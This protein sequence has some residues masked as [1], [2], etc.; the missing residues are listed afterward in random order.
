MREAGSGTRGPLDSESARLRELGELLRRTREAR[1][2]TI[3][4]AVEATK[5][6]GRYL[7]AIEQGNLLVLPG[8]VYARGFVRSYAEYLG[9]DGMEVTNLYLGRGDNSAADRPDPSSRMSASKS[10]ATPP[11]ARRRRVR[12]RGYEMRRRPGTVRVI[13][14]I[15]A[16]VVIFTVL[17]VVYETQVGSQAQGIPV[18]KPPTGGTL[19]GSG[20]TSGYAAGAPAGSAQAG[21][22]GAVQSA[23]AAKSGSAVTL[24]RIA[25]RN[26]QEI[27]SVGGRAPITVDV[28]TAR[29][30]SWM[31]VTV[32]GSVVLSRTVP[33]G[34]I[35]R[36]SGVH[37]VAVALGRGPDVDLTV[38]GLPVPPSPQWVFTYDFV[39]KG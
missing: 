7:K 30:E 23:G 5:V 2:I 26:R 31:Q 4:Q 39:K 38:N 27:F 13:G 20:N 16:L 1:G 34:R 22:G 37:D 24:T 3:D 17:A 33:K 35:L 8:K 6:R 18:A 32:D 21:N 25:V 36:F 29:G 19:G 9:L 12:T 10:S 11:R 15:T 28:R 14:I